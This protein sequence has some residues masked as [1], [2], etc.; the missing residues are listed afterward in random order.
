LAEIIS[1]T[2]WDRLTVITVPVVRGGGRE[3]I[4]D[5]GIRDMSDVRIL[6]NAAWWTLSDMV[7]LTGYR[8]CSETFGHR[9]AR[10][11]GDTAPQPL[12]LPGVE[13]VAAPGR[14]GG[15]LATLGYHRP[16]S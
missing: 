16:N 1:G 11:I 3:V 12:G 13:P 5:L 14:G 8:D 6:N 15:V 7:V 9:L 10:T 4:G 2:A